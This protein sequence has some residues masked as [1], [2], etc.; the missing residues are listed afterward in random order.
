[1]PDA[2]SLVLSVTLEADDYPERSD[3]DIPSIRVLGESATWSLDMTG[4]P[5]HVAEGGEDTAAMSSLPGSGKGGGD[6]S[7]ESPLE[8]DVSFGL[9]GD[10]HR[11]LT[12][13]IT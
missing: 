7:M 2:N 11:V 6:I 10:L 5:D 1:V 8:D 3:A 9:S 12:T 4:S 13:M